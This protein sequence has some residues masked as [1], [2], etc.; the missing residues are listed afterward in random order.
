M[1][2]IKILIG[3]LMI[4]ITVVFH[5]TALVYLAGIL[6]R[7][8]PATQIA[9]NRFRSIMMLSMMVFYIVV[10]HTVEAFSW[11]VLYY[12]LGEFAEMGQALYFSVV[13][14]TT[15]GYGDLTMSDRWQMLAA[16][17]AMGGLILFGVTIAFLF[18]MLRPFFVEDT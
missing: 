16:F 2:D 12:A 14:A 1:I 17:E 10:V 7:L 6:T 13:T 4:I 9:V 15:L 8:M 3:T 11:A 18:E 5:V